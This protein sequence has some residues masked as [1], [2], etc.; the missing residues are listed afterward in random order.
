M[1]RLEKN[2]SNNDEGFIKSVFPFDEAQKA[3]E[4]AA[5]EVTKYQD[6]VKRQEQER[7]NSSGLPLG[8]L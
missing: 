4:S 7:K 1:D 5:K 8:L 6:A 3:Q 2:T